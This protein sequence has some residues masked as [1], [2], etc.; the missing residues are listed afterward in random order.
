MPKGKGYK[1]SYSKK[2]SSGK[3]EARQEVMVGNTGA[4]YARRSGVGMQGS[5]NAVNGPNS[6]YTMSGSAKL[7]KMHGTRQHPAMQGHREDSVGNKSSK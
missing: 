2:S 5:I 1:K 7:P 4:G 6:K 3:M